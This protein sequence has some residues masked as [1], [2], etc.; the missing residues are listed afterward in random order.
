MNISGLQAHNSDTVLPMDQKWI[1]A[2]SLHGH[3]RDTGPIVLHADTD[4]YLT[5]PLIYNSAW[6]MTMIVYNGIAELRG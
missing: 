2:A 4:A 5:V 3:R 1:R 6:V